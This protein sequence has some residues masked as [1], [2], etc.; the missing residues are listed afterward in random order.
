MD[1][2]HYIKMF[3]RDVIEKGVVSGVL[4]RPHLVPVRMGKLAG[5]RFGSFVGLRV[6][7]N[8]VFAVDYYGHIK[9]TDGFYKAVE[10]MAREKGV[11]VKLY[12]APIVHFA[13]IKIDKMMEITSSP[14]IIIGFVEFKKMLLKM[15]A[16]IR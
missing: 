12:Q 1:W 2:K 7:S 16:S 9:K 11:S 5:T 4:G 6:E 13:S 3:E 10:R 14:E 8:A 15:R